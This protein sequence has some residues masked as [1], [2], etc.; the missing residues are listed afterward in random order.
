MQDD[1]SFM[2]TAVLIEDGSDPCRLCR[3]AREVLVE[4]RP[5]PVHPGTG[6]GC[7]AKSLEARAGDRREPLLAEVAYPAAGRPGRR[8]RCQ[9]EE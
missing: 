7:A 2:R 8:D 6:E 5:S 4:V 3:G 1:S 9:V